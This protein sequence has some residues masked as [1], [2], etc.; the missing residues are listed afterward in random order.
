MVREEER[1]KR[2]ARE[3]DRRPQADAQ[4]GKKQEEEQK[5]A[6]TNAQEAKKQKVQQG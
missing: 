5:K 4:A 2:R 1:E 6:A 3:C